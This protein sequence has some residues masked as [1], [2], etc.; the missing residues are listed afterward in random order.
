MEK[1]ADQKLD[2]DNDVR[3]VVVSDNKKQLNCYQ[4]VICCKHTCICNNKQI[5]FP[6]S[7]LAS[8]YVEAYNLNVC[9][10]RVDVFQAFLKGYEPKKLKE[11]LDIVGNGVHI[12]SSKVVD[13]S[14]P[15]PVNQKST[16]EF[17]DLVDN[18]LMLELKENRIAGP[19]MVPLP[20]LIVSPLGAVPKKELGKIRIIH[21]LSHPLKN[22]VN[23]HI[24]R[25]F[26]EVEYEL[27]DVCCSL[28]FSLGSG[29]LMAKGDL[30]Q[31]FRLLRVC[32]SDLK[33]LG[34]TWKGLFYFDKMM[35]MG[36]AI[37]CAQFEK[38]SVAI[39]WILQNV[40]SV[41]N[42]S[43]ILDDFLFFGKENS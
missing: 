8:A 31:A 37:S 17:S 40:F 27:I 10:I 29:C 2:N 15:I 20:G 12:P 16:V 38:F 7:D 11:V 18:M 32:L 1:T 30:C 22:S 9:P 23:S 26:C 19:F 5:D 36:A 21:N 35:P 43:H 42:M 6:S 34:F 25:H 33:F 39:Q 4:C 28:V 14:A 3:I 41:K 24:P 13:V